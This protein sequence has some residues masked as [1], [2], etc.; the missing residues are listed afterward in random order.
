MRFIILIVIAIL[1]SAAGYFALQ[2]AGEPQKPQQVVLGNEPQ[3]E[4]VSVLVARQPI[5]VGT[6]ITEEMIDQQ[7]WPKHLLLEGFVLSGAPDSNLV[8]MVARSDFQAQEPLIRNKLASTADANFIAA[9]L[10]SG[11]RAITLAIDAVSGIA[12]YVF[13]GDHV[14][15]VLTHNIPNDMD[16]T[17]T[18]TVRMGFSETL[19]SGIKVV[20]VDSRTAKQQSGAE[21]NSQEQ[22][23]IP[24]NITLAVTPEDAQ[25]IRLGEK[26]GT[27]SLVL[28]SLKDRESTDKV[29]ATDVASLAAGANG[30]SVIIVRGVDVD[31]VPSGV[32]FS[33]A[34]APAVSSPP[35]PP[36][37]TQPSY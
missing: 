9:S 5:A 36:P 28:R 1:A 17:R 32:V 23:K 25:R 19:L 11:M 21:Q 3:V 16:Q 12:G 33:P 10:P 8:G 15:V 26:N 24:T 34:G 27:L 7:P 18:N 37:Y 2:L 13:P 6:I 20:A 14:D 31:K 30:N 35:P 4:A 29:S 22:V